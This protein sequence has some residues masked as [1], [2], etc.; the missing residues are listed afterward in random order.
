MNN[1]NQRF[2]II[3]E[4]Q[5]MNY[6]SF[7]RELGFSPQTI[8]SIC[9]GRNK[10]SCDIIQSII[11]KYPQYD[12]LWF[13]IGIGEMYKSEIKANDFSQM[14]E[15]LKRENE[16][17][18]KNNDSLLKDKERLWSIVE[19]IGKKDEPVFLDRLAA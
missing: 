16:I 2:A 6:S 5:K 8:K 7:G 19:Q 9:E 15:I 10:P 18:M 4:A 11:E 13:T 1:I 17:L 14:F 3:M 12:P